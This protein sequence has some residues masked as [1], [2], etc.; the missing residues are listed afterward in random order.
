MTLKALCEQISRSDPNMLQDDNPIGSRIMCPEYSLHQEDI[1]TY[2]LQKKDHIFALCW[3]ITS[4]KRFY[5]TIK[6]SPTSFSYG[7][8]FLPGMRTQLHTHEYLEL[9]YIVS[10]SFRQSILGTDITFEQGDL[11]LI[12]KNCLHQDHLDSNS[13]SILFLGIANDVFEDIMSSHATDD[14]IL[15]FLQSALLKQ[16][17]LLQYL[18]FKPNANSKGEMEECL[19]SLLKELILHDEASAIICRGLLMRIFRILSTSYDFS[20]SK[21]LRKEM[22]WLLYEEITAYIKENYRDISIRELCS[23]FHFQ[24]DYFNRILKQ[25]AGMTYIEFVQNLRLIE[26]ERL[27]THTDFS[28]E[29]I[30]DLVGYQNK[31]YFYRLFT[32]HHQMTPAKFREKHLKP[33]EHGV[34]PHS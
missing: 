20:L 30:A 21:E 2:P 5:G 16:K 9:S 22:S 1:K 23:Q 11:C 31:G 10:G 15:S 3:N 12:D 27:L 34:R 17:N 29:R 7:C 19:S 18:H 4:D 6:P 13:A 32:K 25:K 26:A 14:R 8:S 24:E 28:I 33:K